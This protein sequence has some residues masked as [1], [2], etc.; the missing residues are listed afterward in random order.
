MAVRRA[1]IHDG[2]TNARIG[3]ALTAVT[4]LAG[5]WS[6]LAGHLLWA[7]IALVAAATYAAPAA[8]AGDP[9]LLVPWPLLAAGTA[10][11][12][13]RALGLFPTAAA[14]VAVAT[15]AL[16]AVAALDAFTGLDASRRFA[17]ALAVMTT[18]ALQGLWTVA[19]YAADRLLGTDFLTTQVALQRDI[20]V[21]SAV[22]LGA[23]VLFEWYVARVEPVGSHRRPVRS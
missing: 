13:V 11:V 10:A 14:A 8:W 17:V 22:A 3:W 15:L 4:A 20:A 12:V 9:R 1:L 2:R 23:G 19:Q 18:L 16:V 6:A 5:L 21:V 7:G